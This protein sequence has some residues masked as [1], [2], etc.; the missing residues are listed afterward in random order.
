LE[1]LPKGGSFTPLEYEGSR[2][3]KATVPLSYLEQGGESGKHLKR[4]NK[5]N[6]NS[7]NKKRP[8]CPKVIIWGQFRKD[9]EGG[10]C[11]VGQPQA[12]F[13]KTVGKVRGVDLSV[14]PKGGCTENAE[15]E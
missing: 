12:I 11:C 5:S 7:E 13:K 2:A 9:F 6:P 3:V 4:R 15:R 14:A 10:S 1:T 8:S